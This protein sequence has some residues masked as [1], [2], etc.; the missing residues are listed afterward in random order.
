MIT[1]NI[2]KKIAIAS[3]NFRFLKKRKTGSSIILIKKDIKRGIMITFPITIITPSRKIPR[4]S[5][6][7]FMVPGISFMI[8]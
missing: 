4:I 3:G 2:G 7:R 1:N 8:I 5:S 6:E